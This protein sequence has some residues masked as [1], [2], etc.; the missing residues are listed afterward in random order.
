MISISPKKTAQFLSLVVL[1]IT[2]ASLATQFFKIVLGHQYLLG[3]VDLFNVDN[4]ANIPA[5]YSSCALLFCAVLLGIIARGKYS[6]RDRY[7]LHWGGLSFI[8]TLLSLDEA[9]SLHEGW[10]PAV[11][12]MTF[13]QSRYNWVVMG[14]CFSLVVVAVYLKFLIDLPAKFRYRFL[15]AGALFVGG[16]LGVEVPS[17]LHADIHGEENMIYATMVFIEELLE[18]MGVVLFIYTLLLYMTENVKEIY[19]KEKEKSIKSTEVKI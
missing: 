10:L 6:E 3:L 5:W 12:N 17:N 13:T 7:T 16:A 9:V 19:I 18:M 14:A 2:I 1:G 8:F 11:W 4:E 15:L